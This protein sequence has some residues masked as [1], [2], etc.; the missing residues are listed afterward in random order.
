[1]LSSVSPT[2]R[3]TYIDSVLI[4][5]ALLV[6]LHIVEG[7]SIHSLDSHLPQRP[8]IKP[9]SSYP[10]CQC[11]TA[12]AADAMFPTT[13]INAYAMDVFTSNARRVS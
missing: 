5:A 9:I 8:T 4:S 11:G 12:V 10:S 7:V 3:V 2:V 1:M 13:T 6:S